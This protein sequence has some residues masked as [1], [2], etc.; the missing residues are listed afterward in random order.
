MEPGTAMLVSS[1]ISG[2][3]QLVVASLVHPIAVIKPVEQ[4][5]H[6]ES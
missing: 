5:K 2:A 1:L 4:L 6:R 3:F